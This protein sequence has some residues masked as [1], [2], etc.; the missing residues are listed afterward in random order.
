MSTKSRTAV[1]KNLDSPDS[2]QLLN[3]GGVHA[4]VNLGSASIVRAVHEPG[5]RW[6]THLK[7]AVGTDWCQ[8]THVGYMVSGRERVLFEDGTEFDLRPGD[9]Y[10]V[11]PGHDAWVVGDERVVTVNFSGQAD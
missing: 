10:V 1:V 2:T 7:P 4:T 8:R 3:G 6:S 9:A 11:P 5:W